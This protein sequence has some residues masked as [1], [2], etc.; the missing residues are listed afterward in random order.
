MRV[1]RSYVAA[2]AIQIAKVE[3]GIDALRVEI[4][5]NGYDVEIAGALAVAK[6]RAFDAVCAG[7]Q[8]EFGGRDACAAVIV[9]VQRDDRGVALSQIAAEP[10]DLVGVHIRR[11]HFDG[12]GQIQDD[13]VRFG[14]LPDI[15]DGFAN[16]Q[17]ILDFGVGEALRGI[18]QA[19]VGAR[20]CGD[21]AFDQLRAFDSDL[22]DLL[23]AL[24]EGDAALKRRGRVIQVHDGIGHALQAFEGAADQMLTRLHEH[25]HGYVCWDALFFD[26]AADEVELGIAGGGEADLDFFESG[27]DQ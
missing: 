16:F 10:F 22:F 8:A 9:C 12:G 1:T 17:G 15:D 23:F 25:L 6:K 21:E 14:R 24:V 18:L 19:H 4:Q 2:R 20:K 5:R 7:H 11:R 13:L 27:G 26:Q 3:L